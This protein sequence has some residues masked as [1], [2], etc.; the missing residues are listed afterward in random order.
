MV[1]DRLTA[2]KLRNHIAYDLWKYVLLVVG[3]WFGVDLLFAQTAYRSPQDKRVD[4]CIMSATVTDELM[5]SFFEPLWQSA[6]PEM[7]LVEGSILFP[8]SENDPYS[9]MALM[10]GMAAGDGDIYLLPA[11]QF[12]A[13]A[14]QGWFIPLDELVENGTINAE[15]VALD[16]CRLTVVDEET[17]Q[18]YTHLY[19]IPTDSL[20]GLMDGLQYDNRGGVMCVATNSMNEENAV[21]FFNALLQAG[22]GEMPEWL[23]EAR[24]EEAPEAQPTQAPESASGEAAN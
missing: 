6:V 22:R 19:G 5:N 1:K 24:Q 10:T 18:A 16:S 2:A 13:L 14:T 15:G 21:R 3:V 11:D 20:F 7:E 8:I 12:K 17:K 9:G 4:V 23:K